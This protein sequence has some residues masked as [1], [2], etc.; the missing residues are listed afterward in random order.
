MFES[1]REDG[2]TY[3]EDRSNAPATRR[4]MMEQARKQSEQNPLLRDMLGDLTHLEL[5]AGPFFL[6]T[7]YDDDLS[8]ISEGEW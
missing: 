8:D 4:W 6:G 5:M 1:E 3:D 2:D 7:D